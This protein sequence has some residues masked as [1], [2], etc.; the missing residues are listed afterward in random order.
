MAVEAQRKHG[1]YL[2]NQA[3]LTVCCRSDVVLEL[4]DLEILIAW[5]PS[6]GHGH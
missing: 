2:I 3:P 1:S 4:C 6:R 5:R